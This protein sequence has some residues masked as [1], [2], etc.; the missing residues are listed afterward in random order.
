MAVVRKD[1]YSK[2]VPKKSSV[3][4]NLI[5]KSELFTQF[6]DDLYAEMENYFE[7]DQ[8]LSDEMWD[9]GDLLFSVYGI[10]FE[11]IEGTEIVLSKCAALMKKL[12]ISKYEMAEYYM[13]YLA[14]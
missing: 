3:Y 1:L 10:Q 9:F 6:F 4:R 14:E 11:N 5:L 8:Q 2:S 13:K 12:N 7:G